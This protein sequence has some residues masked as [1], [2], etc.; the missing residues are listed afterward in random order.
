VPIDRRLIDVSMLSDKER[1]WVDA[2][3]ATVKR[4]IAPQLDGGDLAWLEAQCA[5]L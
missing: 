2:Y 5:P 1:R 3:H 4:K